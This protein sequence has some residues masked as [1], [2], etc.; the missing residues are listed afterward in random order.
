LSRSKGNFKVKLTKNL[1]S[2]RETEIL[3]LIAQGLTSLEIGARL[4]IAKGTV[5]VHREHI[6]RKLGVRNIAGLVK[7]A[8]RCGLLPL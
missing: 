5:E 1:L 2:K 6:L 4:C 7:I 3:G 8:M